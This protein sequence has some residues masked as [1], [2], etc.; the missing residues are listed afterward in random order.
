MYGKR[1]LYPRVLTT[2]DYEEGS[3]AKVRTSPTTV[4]RWWRN[5]SSADEQVTATNHYD[6]LGRL[7]VATDE[8]SRSTAYRYDGLG[9]VTQVDEGYTG[10][11]AADRETSYD[12]C[13]V[14]RQGCDLPPIFGPHV[15]S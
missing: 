10:T 11:F 8:E 2:Y 9:R 12:C 4:T 5:A 7:L 1:G 6:D 13:G 14:S 15:V 3:P